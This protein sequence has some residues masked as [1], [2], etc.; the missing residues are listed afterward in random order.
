MKDKLYHSLTPEQQIE[1]RKLRTLQT[2]VD[3]AGRKI[4]TGCLSNKEA[5]ELAAQTRSA[6]QK[7]IPDQMDIYDMIYAPRFRHW[8]DN[9]CN[10]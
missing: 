2:I 4:V 1:D 5:Q 3:A 7:I 6:A 10:D 9:F 8:I